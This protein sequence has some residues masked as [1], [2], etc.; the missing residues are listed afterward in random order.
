MNFIWGLL[1]IASV[2]GIAFLLS[3]NRKAINLRT[4]L[5]GL[6]IQF[7]FAFAVLKWDLGKKH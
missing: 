4:I 3:S 5:G 2:L 7:A 1:G 6:A